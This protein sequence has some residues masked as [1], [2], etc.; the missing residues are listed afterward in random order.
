MFIFQPLLF[1][2][3]FS[4]PRTSTRHPRRAMFNLTCLSLLGKQVSKVGCPGSP[5]RGRLTLW[6]KLKL[7][8]LEGASEGD[9]STEAR[10]ILYVRIRCIRTL[11]FVDPLAGH[12][13]VC[14]MFAEA[15][16][17]FQRPSP[18]L[19]GVFVSPQKPLSL[20]TRVGW[21]ALSRHRL[22]QGNSRSVLGHVF[23]VSSLSTRP[24]P[25]EQARNKPRLCLA[26]IDGACSFIGQWS[27]PPSFSKLTGRCV[28]FKG[29]S[30]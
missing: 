3:R 28:L 15:A 29:Y 1:T 2:F 27:C 30:R 13:C 4:V 10:Y 9:V 6:P 20:F 8:Q 16:C 18:T 21:S 7:Q 11:T 17:E 24:S 23:I 5:S 12:N 19:P 14:T 22:H 25:K 26:V